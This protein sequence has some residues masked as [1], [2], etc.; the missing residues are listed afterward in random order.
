MDVLTL[1]G[2]Q[3]TISGLTLTGGRNGVYGTTANSKLTSLTVNGN[4]AN[5]IQLVD[6]DNNFLQAL[7]VSGQAAGAGIRLS[8]ARQNTISGNTVQGNR[9]NVLV[10]INAARQASGNIIQGNTLLDPGQWSVSVANQALTTSVNFNVF[11]TATTSDKYI[12][13]TD[14]AL[15]NARYNWFGGENP[16][17]GSDFSGNINTANFYA[18]LPTVS[19]FPGDPPHAAEL[20]RERFGDGT[21]PGTAPR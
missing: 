8:G 2:N 9:V 14:P 5:G 12:Q 4:A 13:N 6:A 17:Q 10:E 15:L 21:H 16:P 3:L 19:I 7:T 1:A 11:N 18:T 20:H